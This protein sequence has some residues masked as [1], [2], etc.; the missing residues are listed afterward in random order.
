MYVRLKVNAFQFKVNAPFRIATAYRCRGYATAAV[1]AV[2]ASFLSGDSCRMSD[3]API[4][5]KPGK[6]E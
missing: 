5:A 1:I 3:V 6:A 2:A 4:V